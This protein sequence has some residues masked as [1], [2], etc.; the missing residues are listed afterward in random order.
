MQTQIQCNLDSI[1]NQIFCKTKIRIH[2]MVLYY[3]KYKNCTEEGKFIC[4]F[5]FE[6][7]VLK[8]HEKTQCLGKTLKYPSSSYCPS[9]IQDYFGLY[10]SGWNDTFKSGFIPDPDS[11]HPAAN[12]NLSIGPPLLSRYRLIPA[13]SLLLK[14]CNPTC[15]KLSCILLKWC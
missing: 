14:V 1:S 8:L 3:Q 12:C 11:Y 7:L 9:C 10:W 5:L 2:S 4:H 6:K 15:K 13:P